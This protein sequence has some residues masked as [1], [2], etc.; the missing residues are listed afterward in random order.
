MS[1]LDLRWLLQY[2]SKCKNVSNLVKFIDIEL[3]FDLELAE[4]HT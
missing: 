2:I 1:K 3:K 4:R